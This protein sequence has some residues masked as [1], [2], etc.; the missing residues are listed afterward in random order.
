MFNFNITALPMR[1][2]HNNSQHV[3]W[4][5]AT[6]RPI[7]PIAIEH[8]IEMEQMNLHANK[9]LGNYDQCKIIRHRIADARIY[10][11]SLSGDLPS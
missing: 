7:D 9:M 5:V 11:L 6:L 4:L 1:R 8:F 3:N 2:F 10:L